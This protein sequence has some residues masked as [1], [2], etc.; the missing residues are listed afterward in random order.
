MDESLSPPGHG[1]FLIS[2]SNLLSSVLIYDPSLYQ[3]KTEKCDST[4]VK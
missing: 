4:E 3:I 1:I 2:E